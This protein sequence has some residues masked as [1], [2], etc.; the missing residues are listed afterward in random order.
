MAAN[1]KAPGPICGA[2]GRAH[3]YEIEEGS[4][5]SG[6]SLLAFFADRSGS[7]GADVGP[8]ERKAPS[9]ALS[10]LWSSADP[11]IS[12][13]ATSPSLYIVSAVMPSLH[14]RAFIIKD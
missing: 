6:V 11:T 2:L 3:E 12:S 14:H 5:F 13:A 7:D 9:P 1:S 4:T 10:A 8:I